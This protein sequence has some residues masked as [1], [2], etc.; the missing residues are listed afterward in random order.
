MIRKLSVLLVICLVTLVAIVATRPKSGQDSFGRRAA[1]LPQSTTPSAAKAGAFSA[2]GKLPFAF[3]QN[4]GQTDEHVRFLARGGN[5]TLFLT[6]N[7]AVLRLEIPVV[8]RPGFE[9][10]PAPG[11]RKAVASV[12][13]S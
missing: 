7:E 6:A 3:E 12:G 10:P 9:L 11:S 2:Y 8:H 13:R 4:L 5:Y 1:T